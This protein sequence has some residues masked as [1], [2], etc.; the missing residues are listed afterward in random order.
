[1]FCQL[2]YLRHCLRQRIRR[3]LDELPETLDETYDRTLE[4]IGK[5]DWEY[6]RRLFRCVAAA[7]RPLRVE[8]LAESLAFDFDAESTPTFREDWREEDPER[9]VLST[10]SSLLVIAD[11]H[12]SPVIQFTHF[13]VKEY[14]MSKRLA[15]AKPTISRF[16]V[17]MTLAHTIVAQACLS[18][19]LHINEN[20]TGSD[21]QRFPLAEYTA[22]HWVGHARFEN[23]SR[24]IQDG[25]RCLFDPNHR[26]L[27]VWIWIYD[28]KSGRGRYGRPE[29][30]SQASVIP[31]HYTACCG[32][33]DVS[34]S[35]SSTACKT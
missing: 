11:K 15:E 3:A 30:P 31:L 34:S 9:A 2:E 28:P 27:S 12:D 8:E 35:S 26:H 16:H 25:M 1:M 14:L 24:N 21:L 33:R 19:L 4:E 17:S 32:L 23:V 29:R 10:C 7:S 6:A 20:I 22:E 13:S 18:A 5:K